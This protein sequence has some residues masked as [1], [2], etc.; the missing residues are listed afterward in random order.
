VTIDLKHMTKPPQNDEALARFRAAAMEIYSDRVEHIAL[1]G[2]CACSDTKPDSDYDIVVFIKD[3]GTFTNESAR[4]ATIS[5]DILLD[6]GTVLFPPHRFRPEPIA[7]ARASCM[8]C[9]RTVLTREGRNRRL[10]RKGPCRAC[11]RPTGRGVAPPSR[12]RAK[13]TLPCS[14]LTRLTFSS[15]P[16]R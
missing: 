5:M 15:R 16:A 3:A 2:S 14:I 1:F 8:S 13:P 7:N 6:T 11:R 9:A 10:S 12:C 4:L